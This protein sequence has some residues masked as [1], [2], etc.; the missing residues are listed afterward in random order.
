MTEAEWMACDDPRAMLTFLHGRVSNRKLWL[1]TAACCRA[2]STYPFRQELR[3][4]LADLSERVLEGELSETALEERRES[5]WRWTEHYVAEQD[6]ESAACA[7]DFRNLLTPSQEALSGPGPGWLAKRGYRAARLAD[8][9]ARTPAWP[10]SPSCHA[11]TAA[12]LRDLLGPLPFRPVSLPPEVCLWQD[13]TVVR[14]AQ[15]I[16]QERAW[17]RLPILADALEEAGCADN[18][19]L[20][21]LRSP[22][23]HLRGCWVIDLVRG[24]SPPR[25]A[26]ET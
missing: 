25:L 10:E 5:L 7:R 23:A 19:V 21:H 26:W 22:G 1:F 3:L 12:A 20:G 8:L 13:G 11:A 9:L 24:N 15:A 17:D 16:D 4:A 2:G 14:L 6:F 18:A